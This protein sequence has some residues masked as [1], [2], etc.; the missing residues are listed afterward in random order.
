MRLLLL[1]VV[2]LLLAVSSRSQAQPQ[3]GPRPPT[4][5][6]ALRQENCLQFYNRT[7]VPNGFDHYTQAEAAMEMS[8]YTVMIQSVNCSDESLFLLCALYFPICTEYGHELSIPPCRSV[9]LR[10]R[11]GCEKHFS[12][13]QL[14]WPERLNCDNLPN[15]DGRNSELCMS[16]NGT[17]SVWTPTPTKPSPRG[18]SISHDVGGTTEEATVMSSIRPCSDP[19]MP[20]DRKQDSFGGLLYCRSESSLFNCTI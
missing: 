18:G 7:V 11:R 12:Q 16:D 6:E 8:H 3:F 5:C 1:S 4:R 9:C 14:P 17:E 2:T 10:V 13:R 19:L 15:G 20:S